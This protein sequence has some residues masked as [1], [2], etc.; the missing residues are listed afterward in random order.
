MVARL[1]RV[2]LREAFPSEVRDFSKWLH[3][4]ID[5]LGRVVSLELSNPGKERPAGDFSVDLIAEDNQG[6]YV[7]IENQLG[8]SDHD[9][10]GKVLTYM[11]AFEAKAAIWIMET[12]RVE[13]VNA[14]AWLN[15]S[16]SAN[17]Y[18]VKLEAV[19]IGA[20]DVAPLMTLIVGP[21]EDTKIITEEKQEL[22]A[23]H[24]ERRNFW[25]G[26]LE[27][28]NK[29][30]LLHAGRSPTNGSWLSAGAGKRGIDFTYAIRQHDIQI[31]VY[32]ARG[33]GQTAENKQIFDTLLTKKDEI[34]VVFG[35]PQLE[36]QR[37]EEREGCRIRALSDL[38]GYRDP[39]KWPEIYEWMSD[40]MVALE[41]AFRP[42][43]NVL[44]I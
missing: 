42:H 13:H 36:W 14:M 5:E 19:R 43:I 10:L 27:V 7:I 22:A 18:M 39:E 11:T 29:K 9:H 41:K 1:E 32:I 28:A 3:E 33:S 34:Q 8:K 20:S 12:P 25:E 16:S 38:G 15:Q 23:R 6:G 31:E 26:F 24:V 21:S 17:F 35:E 2:K 37:L 30:T 4:N 44:K 40:H